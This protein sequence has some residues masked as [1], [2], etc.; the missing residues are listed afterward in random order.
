[1]TFDPNETPREFGQQAPPDPNTP[2]DYPADVG[3]PPPIYPPGYPAPSYPA[4]S[5]PAPGFYT[6]YDPYRPARPVGTNG[7]AIAALV[8]SLA[9]LAL[10]GS[11]SIVSL[12]LGIIAMRDTKRSGQDGYGLAV[13]GVILSVLPLLGWL[14]YWLLFAVLLTSGWSLV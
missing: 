12:I 4:P 11:T 13:A 9:S 3:L 1:M 6:P 8:V 7:L 10:C 2:V 14:L 5:Y